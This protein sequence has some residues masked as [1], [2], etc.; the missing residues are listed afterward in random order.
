MSYENLLKNL[1]IKE[2]K[3]LWQKME[4]SQK[5]EG[6]KTKKQTIWIQRNYIG[7]VDIN[8]NIEKSA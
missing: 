3:L 6:S 5:I 8:K 1:R 7:V 2:R 4:Q